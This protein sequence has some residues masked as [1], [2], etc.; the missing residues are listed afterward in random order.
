MAIIMLP[1][2]L[3]LAFAVYVAVWVW[4]K[5]HQL[6]QAGKDPATF[7]IAVVVVAAFLL[8][9]IPVPLPCN[10]GGGY[11]ECHSNHCPGCKGNGISVRTVWNY[12]NR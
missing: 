11:G 8:C 1:L 2:L 10:E 3:A 12:L 5:I 7:V 9:F 4:R 6:K